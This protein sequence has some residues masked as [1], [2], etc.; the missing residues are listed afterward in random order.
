MLKCFIIS[1]I[2][3]AGIYLYLYLFYLQVQ[4]IVM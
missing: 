1:L 2:I 3:G 4:G